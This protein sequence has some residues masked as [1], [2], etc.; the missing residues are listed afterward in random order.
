MV[1]Y[2]N[3][4]KRGLRDEH[5]FVPNGGTDSEPLFADDAMPDGVY[6]VNIEGRLDRVRIERGRIYCCN[7]EA[8]AP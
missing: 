8:P 2:I 6:P 3:A 4:V 1:D 5:G 7:F